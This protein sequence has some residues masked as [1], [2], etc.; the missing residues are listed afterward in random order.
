M[1]A[2]TLALVRQLRDALDLIV[3]W[4]EAD[5]ALVDHLIER[6]KTAREAADQWLANQLPKETAAAPGRTSNLPPRYD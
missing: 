2:D 1:T 4:D 6:A 5:L 3:Q